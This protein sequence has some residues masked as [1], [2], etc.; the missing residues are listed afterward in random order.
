MKQA[1]EFRADV[2]ESGNR[3]MIHLEASLRM[4]AEGNLKE[5]QQSKYCTKRAGAFTE[6]G[7]R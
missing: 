3:R 4:R 1:E 5:R 6:L 7:V 2:V